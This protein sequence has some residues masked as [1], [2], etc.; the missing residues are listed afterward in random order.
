MRT[1]QEIQSL[2]PTCATTGLSSD[3]VIRSRNAFGKNVLTPIASESVWLKFLGKFDDAIIRIL[4]VAAILSFFI[5]LFQA[6]SSSY[7]YAGLAILALIV[8][9]GFL[10]TALRPFIPASLAFFSIPLFFS[11]SLLAIRPTKD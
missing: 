8:L 3:E 7:A 10:S 5:E 4:L 1:I 2:F 9:P 6:N 11:A